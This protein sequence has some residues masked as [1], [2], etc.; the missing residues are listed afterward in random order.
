VC[1]EG[2]LKIVVTSVLVEGVVVVVVGFWLGMG[3]NLSG[4]KKVFFFKFIIPLGHFDTMYV[5]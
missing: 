3:E 1:T 5:E 4:I 2:L